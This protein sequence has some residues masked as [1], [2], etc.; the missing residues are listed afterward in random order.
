LCLGAGKLVEGIPDFFLGNKVL[1]SNK[2]VDEN[3]INRLCLDL[4]IQFPHPD[5]N[6]SGYTLYN[7]PFEMKTR[8]G[9]SGKLA[10]P[11]YHGKSLLF[12]CVERH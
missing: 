4:Y 2:Q 6:P 10:E 3:I 1:D 7:R 9:D 11:F 12:Y 8:P 5:G